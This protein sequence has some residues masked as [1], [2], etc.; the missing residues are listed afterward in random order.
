RQPSLLPYAQPER[1][2][3]DGRRRAEPVRRAALGPRPATG[4]LRPLDPRRSVRLAEPGVPREGSRPAR[5][6]ARD[7]SPRPAAAERPC[8]VVSRQAIGAAPAQRPDTGGDMRFFVM[9]GV[10]LAVCTLGSVA[11]AAGERSLVDQVK[12]GCKA[13][14]ESHCKD[15]TP[16]DGRL[17]ACLYAFE[18]KLS[19]RCDYA[20]YDA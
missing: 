11:G 14:L 4:A 3:A 5:L 18:D 19:P 12:E 7:R 8:R 10:G 2:L 16:G 20:L 1:P 17:L 15:V 6:A 13:E 9:L